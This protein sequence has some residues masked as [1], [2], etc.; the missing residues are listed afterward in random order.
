MDYTWSLH[1]SRNE[2]SPKMKIHCGEHSNFLTSGP[3]LTLIL[4]LRS[5]GTTLPPPPAPCPLATPSL[6][7]PQP[8]AAPCVPVQ[9]KSLSPSHI[10]K[11]DYLPDSI[12]R[13]A[14]NCRPD[15]SYTPSS[16]CLYVTG[17]RAGERRFSLQLLG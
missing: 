13:M 7:P 8:I 4:G 11:I 12:G 9:L 6:L 16:N 1:L 14:L 10:S 17:V 15:F 5:Y 2:Y 3:I